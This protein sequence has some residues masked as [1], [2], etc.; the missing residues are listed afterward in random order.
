MRARSTGPA[1][2][3]WKWTVRHPV[4]C[5]LGVLF[6]VL[7][8][9]AAWTRERLQ[10]ER[11][12][13]RFARSLTSMERGDV[14]QALDLI[15]EDVADRGPSDVSRRL[16]F[17]LVSRPS[18]DLRKEF[19]GTSLACDFDA[20]GSRLAS[21]GFRGRSLSLDVH[22]I[23]T[24]H[25]VESRASDKPTRSLTLELAL[26]P[27]GGESLTVWNDRLGRLVEVASPWEGF[28]P[29]AWLA[30]ESYVV[31][32]DQEKK[33]VAWDLATRHYQ[34]LP[35]PGF[36]AAL[37]GAQLTV[38]DRGALSQLDLRTGDQSSPFPSHGTLEVSRDGTVAVQ[39]L[40]SRK[41]VVWS[42]PDRRWVG[43]IPLAPEQRDRI[44]LSPDGR[45]LAVAGDGSQPGI[46]VWDLD[47]IEAGP[48]HLEWRGTRELFLQWA[49][50]SSDSR[51]LAVTGLLEG[52][53][54]VWI[55]NVETGREVGHLEDQFSPRWSPEAHRLCTI[56]ASGSAVFE[57]GRDLRLPNVSSEGT[58]VWDGEFR[59]PS[60]RVDHPRR[61]YRMEKQSRR[62]VAGSTVW[63]F[64]KPEEPPG[65]RL[66]QH[67]SL[68][69]A[70]VAFIDRWERPWAVSTPEALENVEF[71]AGL[72]SLERGRRKVTL[73]SP[74]LAHSSAPPENPA[75]A[76]RRLFG[77]QVLF[78]R[79]EEAIWVA[80]PIIEY[81]SVREVGSPVGFAVAAWNLPDGSLISSESVEQEKIE[82]NA[83][84]LRSDGRTLAL[85]G[86][87][88]EQSG[89][90]LWDSKAGR[91]TEALA[92]SL[93]PADVG[94]T[95]NGA[96]VVSVGPD[97]Q[98]EVT[99]V[100]TGNFRSWIDAESETLHAMAFDFRGQML[101]TA[102][103]PANVALWDLATG[104]LIVRWQAHPD[105]VR[106]LVF[107]PRNRSLYSLGRDGLL[108]VWD[109]D[110]IRTELQRLG[111][112]WQTSFEWS[113][114]PQ[115]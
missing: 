22:E 71:P 2:R 99:E 14:D 13:T 54:S 61:D 66:V 40:A 36:P 81:D 113:E 20:E 93:F 49:S 103:E 48:R 41:V 31:A 15:A 96:S 70:E 105:G 44:R 10:Q 110:S 38:Q 88:A 37:D 42:L 69:D 114:T 47:A 58:R 9:A 112:A 30:G 89:V 74:K 64:S 35:N 72:V 77:Q 106:G 25:L 12:E 63:A 79:N 104:E 108:R 50:F 27:G 11:S 3:V 91:V 1:G 52:S 102:G 29:F 97:S 33:M 32:V 19:D 34:E 82:A 80:G 57:G 73:E 109:L 115:G 107:H 23:E 46:R 101:A 26:N 59:A 62:L 18:F 84:A 111:L 24:G 21:F 6:A 75:G 17:E 28:E 55:W 83:W 76:S 86:R 4:L 98:I 56:E 67:L 94:F 68:E 8:V 53:V 43:E 90:G 85:A 87:I 7:V 60:Y 92:H 5:G 95:P 100:A 16:A 39:Y 51:Y 45:R 65:L 78:P